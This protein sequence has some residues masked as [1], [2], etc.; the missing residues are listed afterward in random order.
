MEH[1]L[2]GDAA[3]VLHT[4]LPPKLGAAR[5]RHHR[6]G[7]KVWFG[8]TEVTKAHYEAQVVGPRHV[9]E[10]Q[11]LALEVGFHLEHPKPADNEQVITD[12]LRHEQRWRKRLGDEAVA[13]PFLG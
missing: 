13:G 3:D 12:L 10:A 5:M 1:D 4:L 9:P 2:F 11:V 6:Y 8:G 7:L